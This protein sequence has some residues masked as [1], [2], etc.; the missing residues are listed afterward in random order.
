[1]GEMKDQL[2]DSS[3]QGSSG[4]G[5]SSPSYGSQSLGHG[6]RGR[7]RDRDHDPVEL[8]YLG[9]R[10]AKSQKTTPSPIPMVLPG[11]MD[12]GNGGSSYG[13]LPRLR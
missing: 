11:I 10:E 9:I 2:M 8:Q 5:D 12:T 4:S 7:K 6:D 1:M 13:Y 3:G